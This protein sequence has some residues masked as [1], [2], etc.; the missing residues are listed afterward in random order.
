MEDK[1]TKT[2]NLKEIF[3][4]IALI[5]VIVNII[6]ASVTYIRQINTS[7]VTSKSNE[8]YQY[9]GEIKQEYI[10]EIELSQEGEI[11]RLKSIDAE[12]E[13]DSTPVYFKNENKVIFPEDMGIVVPNQNSIA[14]KLP[15]FSMALKEGNSVYAEINNKQFLVQNSL[16]FF[17]EP[18]TIKIDEEEYELSPLSYVCVEYNGDIEIYNKQKDEIKVLDIK[19]KKVTAENKNY[20]I[21]L[22]VDSIIYNEKEQLLQKK[23]DKLKILNQ[24]I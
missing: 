14:Y 9:F 11:K 18:I 13:L 2:E 24:I 21:D 20:K 15:R 19:E 7:K 12:I 17:I 16:Y 23:T 6:S 3:V 4:R 10:G 22:N 8:F 5:L 1:K